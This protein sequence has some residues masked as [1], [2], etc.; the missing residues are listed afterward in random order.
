M[1]LLPKIKGCP[2]CGSINLFRINGIIYENNFKSLSDWTLKKLINCR[3]CKIEFGLFIHN[4]NEK[5]EKVVW[6][7]LLQCEDGSLDE[8]IKLQSNKEIYRKKNRNREYKKVLL[9]I[10]N[11]QNK[12]RLDKVKVKIKAK[13][14][15][16]NLF[17]RMI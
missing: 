2:C 1:N 3:K 8:L 7:E 13:M 11:I 5:K 16:Q 14:Q 6:V 10:Q 4:I 12:V 15:N 9:E 17:T